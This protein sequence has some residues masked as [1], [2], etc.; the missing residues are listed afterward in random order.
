MGTACAIIAATHYALR[1]CESD[2]LAVTPAD[3]LISVSDVFQDT[4]KIAAVAAR[5]Y[6]L[7]LLGVPPSAPSPDYGY[8]RIDPA[9]SHEQ[10]AAQ[11]IKQFI[12]KPSVPAAQ[13]L[14]KKPGTYWNAGVFLFDPPKLL[15]KATQLAPNIVSKMDIAI[16]TAQSGEGV[17]SLKDEQSEPVHEGSFDV[18]IV[19]K[20]SN[21]GM[22][23]LNT[24]WRDMGTWA[25]VWAS[26][27]KDENDNLSIGDVVSYQT[28]NSLLITDHIKIAVGNMSDIAVIASGD[29]LMISRLTDTSMPSKLAELAKEQN[30]SP[31]SLTPSTLHRAWGSFEIIRTEKNYSIK[32]LTVAPGKRISLQRHK[33]RTEHWIVLEGQATV[34]VQDKTEVL[35]ANGSAYIPSG[36]LHR[37]ENNTK[38]P[39]VIIETQIG[40]YLGEDDIERFDDD[41]GRA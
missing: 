34:T 19:E 11:K 32:K 15:A 21:V 22:I 27:D 9:T 3:N 1:C 7:V 16:T 2:I 17:I 26:S 5:N 14:L 40:S 29:S 10:L 31:P 39:L 35:D 18:E 37:L 36:H 28:K 30:L 13:E 8:I 25:S 20:C 23:P 41:F 33:Y 4:V 12:E 38:L 6:D 24:T